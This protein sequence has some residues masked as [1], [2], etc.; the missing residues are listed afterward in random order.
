ML[1]IIPIF[2]YQVHCLEI[3]VKRSR[4][5]PCFWRI[6]PDKQS[7][8]LDQY[9]KLKK[10]KIADSQNISKVFQFQQK[11][12][13]DHL[14]KCIPNTNQLFFDFTL[15]SRKDRR[16]AYWIFLYGEI[17]DKLHTKVHESFRQRLHIT[18]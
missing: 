10:E 16:K 14:V 18:V 8:S 1:V 15:K 5:V 12:K 9:G 7:N 13:N 17:D 2:G 4:T 3:L 6:S 11:K